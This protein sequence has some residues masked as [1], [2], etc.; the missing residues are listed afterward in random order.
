[1]VAA[2]SQGEPARMEVW[3]GTQPD[4]VT[5]P[6]YSLPNSPASPSASEYREGP[7]G[8]VVEHSWLQLLHRAEKLGVG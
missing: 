4:H 3:C 8:K 1:M 2:V 6:W 5:F 7:L